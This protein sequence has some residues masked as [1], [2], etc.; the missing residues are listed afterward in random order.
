MFTQGLH[1]DGSDDE[2]YDANDQEDPDEYSDAKTSP[3][4]CLCFMT[5][6]Y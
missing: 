3:P 4:V 5:C 1:L 2:F 6:L